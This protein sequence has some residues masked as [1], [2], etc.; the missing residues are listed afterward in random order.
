MYLMGKQVKCL[1]SS[2]TNK[3]NSPARAA[4]KCVYMQAESIL[5]QNNKRVSFILTDKLCH[6]QLLPAAL[7][8]KYYAS[9]SLCMSRKRNANDVF[10]HKSKHKQ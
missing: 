1:L 4:H 8:A 7:A 6:Y 2:S 10:E 3:A 9:V 5:Q